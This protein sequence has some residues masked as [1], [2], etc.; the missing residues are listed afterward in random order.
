M[1]P[2]GVGA[3]QIAALKNVSARRAVTV[4]LAASAAAFALLLVVIFGHGRAASAPAWISALPA[5]NAALNGTSA[6]FLVLAYL[7]VRRRDFATH[8][9]RMLGALAASA[10]FLV[11]YVVYHS[12]HG[13]S[14][15]GGHGAVRP[16]Y[17]FVLITHV[18]L[19]AAVLPLI[20]SSFFL[21]L[22][23]RLATHKK[24]S[25]YTLPIWLYVSVT[26]VLVYALLRAYG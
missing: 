12:V 19:S 1:N 7:A 4:I 20:F 18:V 22:S 25:R 17:F 6:V 8:A 23:G 11:S 5:L 24:V 2:Q 21:S 26:G 9:R 16:V 15:F 13:D 3:L 14:R 10:L